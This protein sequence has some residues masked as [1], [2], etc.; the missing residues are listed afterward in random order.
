MLEASKLWT[1]AKYEIKIQTRDWLFRIIIGLAIPLLLIFCYASFI[2]LPRAYS[3]ISSYSA[4]ATLSLMTILGTFLLIFSSTDV[5]KRNRF[6]SK[7]DALY[8]RSMTNFEYLLGQAVGLFSIFSFL[9]LLSLVITLLINI[10]NLDKTSFAWQPYVF[11]PILIWFPCFIYTL[12]LTSLLMRLIKNQALVV[13]IASAYLLL[14]LIYLTDKASF[15]FNFTAFHLPLVYSDFVGIPG[16]EII[17]LQR[18]FYLTMGLVLLFSSIIHFHRLPQ[19][20]LSNKILKISTIF[21][22]FISAA[23]AFAHHTYYSELPSERERF[24]DTT[25]RFKKNR[26]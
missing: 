25:E 4:Y 3:G 23:S 13:L 1:N 9:I 19:S 26:L 8:V 11:Y 24:I 10:L 2:G 18:I 20:L 15:L 16:I 7:V 12:G 21:L 22:L 14:D 5:S 6:E 17:I